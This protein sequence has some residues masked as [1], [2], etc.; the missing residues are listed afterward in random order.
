LRG[1]GWA[2]VKDGK[3]ITSG[4]E[5]QLAERLPSNRLS[6]FKQM[7]DEAGADL[8]IGGHRQEGPIESDRTFFGMTWSELEA[9]QQ[10]GG[11]VRRPEGRM[12]EG[13]VLAYSSPRGTIETPSVPKEAD[14]YVYAGNG[15]PLYASRVV[16]NG[17]AIVQ[18]AR[19]QGF[20]S[21]PQAV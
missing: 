5:P 17:D 14:E 2:L 7:A 12:P 8:Y 21:T 3:V 13:S 4:S 18:W 1:Y 6:Y 15:K 19:S 16:S 11:A 10:R 9:K 20:K